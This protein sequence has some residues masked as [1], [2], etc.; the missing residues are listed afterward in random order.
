MGGPASEG[1]PRF[2]GAPSTEFLNYMQYLKP[3]IWD[4]ANYATQRPGNDFEVRGDLTQKGP[5]KV[6]R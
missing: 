5:P 4:V 6:I 2:R 1:G 3:L